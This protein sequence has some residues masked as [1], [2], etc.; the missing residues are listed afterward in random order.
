MID[1]K[2]LAEGVLKNPD[3]FHNLYDCV[4]IV[5]PI[6]KTVAYLDRSYTEEI[7]IGEH[8]CFGLWERG[9][10][11][12]NCISMRA[13]NS[14][15][16]FIKIDY[17]GDKVFMATA[18]PVNT[19]GS[20]HVVE[21]LK[22]ITHTGILDIEG[23]ETDEIHKIIAKRNQALVKDA[24]TGAYNRNFICERLPHDIIRANEKGQPL[25]LVFTS[26]NGFRIINDKYGLMAGDLVAREF[27]KNLRHY[28]GDSR[29]WCAR[30]G[31]AE[32]VLVLNNTT[33]KQAYQTCKRLARK[34]TRVDIAFEKHLIR[35]S[36]DIGFY[37][38]NDEFLT[39]Q[40]LIDKAHKGLY[41]TND[42]DS[43][44]RNEALANIISRL[45]LTVREKE[46][47]VLVLK[48]LNNMEIAE[49]LYV[50]VST[51]KKHISNILAKAEVKSRA[52]FI[53][54][55]TQA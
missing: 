28:C 46:T 45:S 52:E 20:Q 11:C 38:M 13:F 8:E 10:T 22:D 21:L 42:V 37:T 32:F 53:A 26:I 36:A 34:I 6:Q 54:K 40:E 15:N 12:E 41:R 23:K 29:D 17:R 47:A 55:Y 3:F 35:I 30:Y 31:G 50:G 2:T 33:E 24:L 16:A 9:Q 51:V 19:A 48:G 39:S 5:D 18:V 27:V 7:N 14:G 43:R 44:D 1:T 25:T 49:Q 4:R